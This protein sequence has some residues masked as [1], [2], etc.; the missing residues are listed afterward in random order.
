VDAAR[1][2][3]ELTRD[4]DVRAFVL[5]SSLSGLLGNPGQGDYAAG[6]AFLDA[7]A[8]HRRDLGLPATSVAWGTWGQEAGMAER[9]GRADL[10]RMTRSG[11]RALT[12][13]QALAAL[14][15]AL[16]D[17]PAAVAATGIDPARLRAQAVAG[18]LPPLLRGLV[19]VPAKRRAEADA[20]AF[21]ARLAGL[22]AAE[23]IAALTD[24]VRTTAA[25]VLGHESAEPVAADRVFKDLGFD[26]LTAVELRN[27]LGAVLGRRLPAAL[28]FDHPTAGE[29]AAHLASR[30]GDDG[31][32]PATTALADL[33][34]LADGLRRLAPSDPAR[35]LIGARLRDLAHGLDAG[36]PDAD[37]PAAEVD[38]TAASDET[39][40]DVLDSEFGS[41]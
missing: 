21:A 25:A 31:P 5:F 8:E 15:T 40:F 30:L 14:D 35:A 19:R 12:S 29:L 18:T 4:L 6:N 27:R 36:S 32:A 41:L 34:R 22:G 38:L 2:L 17:G 16:L 7:L 24:L 13:E 37:D 28:V 23:R 9:L 39:L 26:S 20:G 11:I 10:H 3:H 1:N 33:D